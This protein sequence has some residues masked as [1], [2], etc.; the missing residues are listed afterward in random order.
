MYSHHFVVSGVDAFHN[1]I[2]LSFIRQLVEVHTDRDAWGNLHSKAVRVYAVKSKVD[3]SYR[4]HINLFES[5][6]QHMFDK[7]VVLKNIT[8][9]P[10]YTPEFANIEMKKGWEPFEEQKPVIEYIVQDGITK[11]IDAQTGQGKELC[12]GT[13]VKTPGGWTK[14]EDLK[15]GDLVMGET[16][17]YHHVTGVYPQGRKD[18]YKFT[19]RDGR[20][21]L[22]GAEH[23]WLIKK[24]VGQEVMS[25]LDLINYRSKHVTNFN[26]TYIPVIDN[27]MEQPDIELP[28]DPY[29]LG[30]L[31][32]DGTIQESR[33]S[34]VKPVSELHDKIREICGRNNIFVS[35]RTTYRNYESSKG[36]IRQ[37]HITSRLSIANDEGKD[38]NQILRD[39]GLMG[40]YSH[41]KFI[42]DIYLRAGTRQ[43][44]ALIQGL[45]DTDGYPGDSN[46]AIEY[47]TISPRLAEGVKELLWSLGAMV[48]VR[49]KTPTYTYKGEKK[50]GQPFYR[51]SIRYRRP[52]ELFSL[53]YK[54]EKLK[55]DT[56]YTKGFALRIDKIEK[57][58]YQEECTCISVDNPTKLFVIKDYIVTHNTVMTMFGLAQIKQRVAMVIKP[59]YIERWL[60]V[61]V[62]DGTVLQHTT[63]KDVIV[64]RGGKQLR[65]LIYMA[66]DGTL[67]AQFIVI[68]N[69]TLSLYYKHYKEFGASE[70]YGL[71]HPE[72]LWKLLGVGVRVID[73]AHEHF[74]VCF[75]TDLNSHV[76]K[77]VELSATLEPDNPFLK[78]MYNIMYPKHLRMNTGAYKRYI[79]V[80]GLTYHILD[81]PK[82]IN[83]SN[84]G[85]TT[86]S[87][88]A[89]ETNIFKQK[90]RMVRLRKMMIGLTERLFMS[91][92]LPEH[93][94]LIFFE[95]IDM[96][97]DI[98]SVLKDKYPDLK[99]SRYTEEEDASV[100][101]THDIIVATPKSAGTA[102]DIKKLQIVISFVMRNSTQAVEQMIGRLR[103]LKTDKLQPKFYYLFTRQIDTHVRY[104]HKK[105]EIMKFKALSLDEQISGYEI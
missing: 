35:T 61:I 22:A 104:H 99:V 77:S 30:I 96:C 85:R 18:L 100:L 68:S 91:E 48:H 81:D 47:G 44:L 88:A 12:N 11:V 8:Y 94:L 51:F 71:V 72:D 98:A 27:I 66:Q 87:Q 1:E 3:H 78:R 7:G 56:Q 97:T 34:V 21:A 74:Y 55:G 24:Q 23:L 50:I 46:G 43:R 64:V 2:I 6:K 69:T 103:Q 83:V 42:P 4:L 17:A 75:I 89:Y 14:I 16:G 26:R 73:E 92:R 80:Y 45:L 38:F 15:V 59:M 39:L 54:K 101:D 63:K 19:F 79:E 25:T 5:F 102:V 60:D 20:T 53:T 28:I 49:I 105:Q 62:G 67:N 82:Y 52:S 9:H 76:H 10:L 36:L 57:L 29:L 84:R 40:T 90:P 37:R 86:Y 93:K 70:E 58:D 41:T 33:V 31:L 95:T 13:L 65:S 32:G